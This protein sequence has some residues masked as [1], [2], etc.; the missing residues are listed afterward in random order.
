MTETQLCTVHEN[1]G[2]S[3]LCYYWQIQIDMKI[4]QHIYIIMNNWHLHCIVQI[5]DSADIFSFSLITWIA[6]YN[7][8]TKLLFLTL[9]IHA[10]LYFADVK[11]NT[12]QTC[13]SLFCVKSISLSGQLKEENSNEK[14]KLSEK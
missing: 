5:M 8:A 1:V 13:F 4:D 11:G 10:V 3:P 14:L 12:N 6:A 9:I 2:I 7:M